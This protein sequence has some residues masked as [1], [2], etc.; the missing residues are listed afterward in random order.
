VHDR[1]PRSRDGGLVLIGGEPGVGKTKLT[2]A[3]LFEARPEYER[4]GR[5]RGVRV[6]SELLGSLGRD[7]ATL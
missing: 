1:I 5:T 2:E 4:Q 3:T 6:C 7:R